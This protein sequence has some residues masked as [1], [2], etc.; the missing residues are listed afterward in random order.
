MYTQMVRYLPSIELQV[1]WQY[2]AQQFAVDA[3]VEQSVT[4]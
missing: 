4:S 2:G 1:G 3:D